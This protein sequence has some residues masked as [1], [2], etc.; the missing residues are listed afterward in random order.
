MIDRVVP[1]D[2]TMGFLRRCEPFDSKDLILEATATDP[3]GLSR[4][5]FMSN[6]WIGF[7]AGALGNEGFFS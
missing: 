2:V 3:D 4:F 7:R 1:R 5:A 6:S